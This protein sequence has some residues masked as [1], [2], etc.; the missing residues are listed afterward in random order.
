MLPG[1]VPLVIEAECRG[2]HIVQVL[3]DG[4]GQHE[5]TDACLR[6]DRGKGQWRG[7]LCHMKSS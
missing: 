4:P 6:V 5:G 7:S 3:Q 2:Q 1:I